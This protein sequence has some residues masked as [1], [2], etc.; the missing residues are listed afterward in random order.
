MIATM[1]RQR[2]LSLIELMISIALGLIIL[3]AVTTLFIDQ[4][5]T[6]TDLDKANRL[7][8]NGRYAL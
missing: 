8:E 1:R 5:K 3:A 2:G 6:R 7:V 4:N